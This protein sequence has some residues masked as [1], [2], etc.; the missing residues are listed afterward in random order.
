MSPERQP[1][2]FFV[3]DQEGV[4]KFASRVLERGGYK[5]I[6]A[7]SAAEA[8][9]VLDRFEGPIEVLL[10][11]INLPDA[12]GGTLAQS[13]RVSHPEMAVIYTT[14]FADSDEVLSSGLKDAALVLPKPFS[15]AE[16]LEKVSMAMGRVREVEPP[17]NPA[18]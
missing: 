13:L 12:W 8:G 18:P 11:D 1:V 2:V 16:L 14:G 4:R 17:E 3:D 5:V 7:G 9:Q 10:M 6:E 15:V